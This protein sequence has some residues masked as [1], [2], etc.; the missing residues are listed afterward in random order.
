VSRES[1]TSDTDGRDYVMAIRLSAFA[2]FRV[3]LRL[4]VTNIDLP[5]DVILLVRVP[6]PQTTDT[7]GG[8]DGESFIRL[9]PTQHV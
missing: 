3:E 4:E 2:R 8:G 7:A 6:P 9:A 5:E 1:R